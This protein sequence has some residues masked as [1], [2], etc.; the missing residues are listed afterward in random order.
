[1]SR[2]T[3]VQEAGAR[4]AQLDAGVHEIER[5]AGQL[6]LGVGELDADRA[7]VLEE[8]AAHAVG[9]LGGGEPAGAGL[10]GDLGVLHG[11]LGLVTSLR[12]RSRSCP[13]CASTSARCASTCLPWVTPT[14][15][16]LRVQVI[17]PPTAQPPWN[18]CVGGKMRWSG[19]S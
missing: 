7:A 19:L 13:F 17:C 9:L 3:G 15:M 4:D 12:S 8:G 11:L 18:A 1:M 5:G 2:P 16:S 6:G 14:P 10:D